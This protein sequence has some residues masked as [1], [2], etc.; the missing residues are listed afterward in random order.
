VIKLSRN[1]AADGVTVV[2]DIAH[3]PCAFAPTLAR[4]DVDGGAA[5][6][7]SLADSGAGVSHKDTRAPQNGQELRSRQVSLELDAAGI[8]VLSVFAQ[9]FGE[10]V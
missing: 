4:A 5:Q 6:I 7:A 3:V 9:P 8:V 1:G 2:G 10:Q